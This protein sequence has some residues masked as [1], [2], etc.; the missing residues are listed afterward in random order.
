MEDLKFRQSTLQNH[1][2]S[3]FYLLKWMS[4]LLE[5]C[6]GNA[7]SMWN[8]INCLLKRCLKPE[9]CMTGTDMPLI[10]WL[11]LNIHVTLEETI[12]TS[13]TI[14][15]PKRVVYD[16]LLCIYWII[17][18]I[19]LAVV[20]LQCPNVEHFDQLHIN[21]KG[22]HQYCSSICLSTLSG[23]PSDFFPPNVQLSHL[24]TYLNCTADYC[25]PNMEQL[26]SS[27]YL[28]GW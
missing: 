18:C 8:I 5:N 19:Y 6:K 21:L 24:K 2:V 4:H 12:Y 14:V 28:L 9:I 25:L 17:H 15:Y 7:S 27:I 16:I 3:I 13:D 26:L 10:K 11:K 23:E 1:D 22:M 20:S